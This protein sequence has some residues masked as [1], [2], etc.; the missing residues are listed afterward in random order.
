[1]ST[2]FEID[3]DTLNHLIDSYTLEGGVRSLK[4]ILEHVVREINL[5]HYYSPPKSNLLGRP[6]SEYPTPLVLNREMICKDIL[7]DRTPILQELIGTVP[8]IGR[9]NGLFATCNDTG[10]LCTI[11]SRMIP[12]SQTM[13]LQLTGQQ[14]SVMKESM[15]VAKSVAW[16]MSH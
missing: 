12:M 11:E 16:Q 3:D 4:K 1:M 9:I 8:M 6:V 7:Q 5:R 2:D 15:K 10:G 13:D 14:G